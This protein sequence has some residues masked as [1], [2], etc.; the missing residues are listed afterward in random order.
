[1]LDDTPRKLL[2][3]IVQFKY[4][5]KRMPTIRELAQL[6]GRKTADIIKGFKVL[7]AEHYILWEAGKAIETAVIIEVWERHVP[8]DTTPQGGAQSPGR[9]SNIDYWMYH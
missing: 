8:Y 3:I 9:G 1:M 4:H 5:K 7:A 6:S 2:R